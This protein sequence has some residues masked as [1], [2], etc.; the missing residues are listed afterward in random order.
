MRN[1]SSFK[2]NALWFLIIANVLIFIIT[3]IQ[4]EAIFLLG[5]TPA[6][7]LHQP[8][9][10]ISNLFV[11][12]GFRHIMFNMISLYFL[13]GFLLRLVGERDF[14]RVYFAGGVVGNIFYI[15]LGPSFI[16][17][18]GASG[19]IFAMGGA[20]AIMVPKVRVFV[21]P[22]PIPIPLWMATIILL[23]LSFL[24]SVA[25]QA[26]LGGFALGLAAGYFFKKRRRAYY[27]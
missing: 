20:L 23:L 10:I 2:F 15:L 8:W 24:P 4:P 14:L 19:A 27:F 25:W 7:F 12:A 17:G 22:I 9:T 13:G 5:L 16:P 21:F 3:L 26:H 11:H 18:V 1:Y 6:Y